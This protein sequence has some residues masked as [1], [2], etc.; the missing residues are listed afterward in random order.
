MPRMQGVPSVDYLNLN[1]CRSF[2]KMHGL[3]WMKLLLLSMKKSE[4]WPFNCRMRISDCGMGL[5]QFGVLAVRGSEYYI[6][7]EMKAAIKNDMNGINS[8]GGRTG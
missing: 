3:L 7:Y 4:G 5:R 2:K 6:N 1:T 8:S